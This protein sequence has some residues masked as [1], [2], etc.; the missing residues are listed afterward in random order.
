MDIQA[1]DKIHEGVFDPK[2]E[3][4]IRLE[5][6]PLG[7]DKFKETGIKLNDFDGLTKNELKKT[8]LSY[9]EF[10]FNRQMV[11]KEKILWNWQKLK[12]FVQEID[13]IISEKDSKIDELK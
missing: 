4:W 8:A 6:N 10:F 7:Y 13:T 11:V 1:F 2:S 5:S 9:L 12:K 3:K